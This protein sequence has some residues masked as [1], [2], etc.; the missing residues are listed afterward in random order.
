MKWIRKGWEKIPSLAEVKAIT[1]CRYE[2]KWDHCFRS[3]EKVVH[4]DGCLIGA[5]AFSRETEPS[6]R[7]LAKR[8]RDKLPTS[9]PLHL[10]FSCQCLPLTKPN[11]NPKG[12]RAPF[13]GVFCMGTA[14]PRAHSRW[15]KMELEWETKRPNR[16]EG[17]N[18]GV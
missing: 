1:S 14:P 18:R 6:P 9:F 10:V 2:G 3:P 8:T 15:A 11:P 13:T 17:Q 5:T 16:T 12:T 7:E 4:G